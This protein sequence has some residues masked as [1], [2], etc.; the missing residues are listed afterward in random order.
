MPLKSASLHAA[1]AWQEPRGAALP[2]WR[3]SSRRIAAIRSASKNICSVRHRP[4][5]SAPYFTATAASCGLS[6]LVR[7]PSL[8]AASAQPIRVAKS[9]LETEASTVGIASAYTLPVVAVDAHPVALVE[10]D[11]ADGRRYLC[12][13]IDRAARRSRR[14]SRCPCRGQQQPRERSCRR[15]RSGCPGA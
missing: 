1:A 9:P 8:R 5:P 14:R 10:D 15:G 7:T 13:F 12:F 3:G 2:S 11:V 4:M 6:A